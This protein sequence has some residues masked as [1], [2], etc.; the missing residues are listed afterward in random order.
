MGGGL[1]RADLFKVGRNL[2]MFT[3][4]KDNRPEYTTEDWRQKNIKV[5]RPI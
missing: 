3:F 5:G 4:A 1:P 2:L